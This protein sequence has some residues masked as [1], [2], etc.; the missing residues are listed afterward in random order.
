MGIL[1]A[2]GVLPSTVGVGLKTGAFVVA[3]CGGQTASGSLGVGGSG[4]NIVNAVRLPVTTQKWRLHIRNYNIRDST[5]YAGQVDF[6]GV[7]LSKFTD[8]ATGWDGKAKAAPVQVLTS[9][10]AADLSTEYVSPWVT[11]ANNQFQAGVG[12]NLSFGYTA[13]TGVSVG[14]GYAGCFYTGNKADASSQGLTRTAYEGSVFDIWIE[15]QA[16]TD[17]PLGLIIGDSLSV[18]RR[19]AGDAGLGMLSS[20]S[21]THANRTKSL[22]TNISLSGATLDTWSSAAGFRMSRWNTTPWDYVVLSLGTNNIDNGDDLASIQTK[23]AT[24]VAQVRSAYP[25]ARIYA[26]TIPPRTWSGDSTAI[27]AKDLIRPAFNLWIQALPFGIH[28]CFR[29]SD[30]ALSSSG[31]VNRLSADVD[32]GDGVHLKTIG[33]QIM[34]K[35]IPAR[36]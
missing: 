20:W 22:N 30:P 19:A 1:D 21:I 3:A 35:A 6:T 10:T 23:Y 34:E 33:S 13:A 28:G 31:D 7:W 32:S 15:Y 11:D 4:A 27:A 14:R 9:W 12:H 16:L 18:G 5:A 2:P 26:A 17:A 36:V 25:T 29:F 8:V 24:T